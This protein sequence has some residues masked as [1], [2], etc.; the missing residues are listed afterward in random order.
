MVRL[1]AQ[2]IK[3]ILVAANSCTMCMPVTILDGRASAE[4]AL[5]DMLYVVRMCSSAKF[6]TRTSTEH[7]WTRLYKPTVVT[8]S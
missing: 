2:F 3:I 6:V 8:Y 7:C 5:L 1:S 4:L